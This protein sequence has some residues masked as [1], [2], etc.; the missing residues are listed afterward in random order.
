MLLNTQVMTALAKQSPGGNP[1]TYASP[2]GDV[3]VSELLG[4]YANLSLLGTIFWGSTAAAGTIIPVNAAN[5]VSTFT[6][7]N[8]SG[9]G[10]NLMLIAY[11]LGI[12][13]VTAVVGNI[14]LVYQASVGN[15]IPIPTSQTALVPTN[16]IIGG[17]GT[18]GARLLSAGTLTGTPTYF[19]TLGINIGTTLEGAGP[20]MARVDFD[21]TAIIPEG[22]LVT[23]TAFA[24]QTAAMNQ[25]FI[26]AEL[27]NK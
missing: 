1:P 11:L 27:P 25:T 20:L 13:T 7:W 26:W 8:P 22:V 12:T 4:K 10:K 6:L 14:D 5:L 23:P 2:L 9:S 24:A 17:G 19:S 18:P 16:A 3:L 21:G 15:A